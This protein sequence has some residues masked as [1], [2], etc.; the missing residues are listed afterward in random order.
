[1][2]KAQTQHL[3]DSR[4]NCRPQADQPPPHP[5]TQR[6]RI[7]Q[8]VW[9]LDAQGHRFPTSVRFLD[10]FC[11]L[12]PAMKAVVAMRRRPDGQGGK[13]LVA[14]ST[15]STPNGD[16][17]VNFV[18]RLFT[19]LAVADDRPLPAH[20]T[21]PWQQVQ[22]ERHHPGSILWSVSGSAIKRITAWREGL[23]LNVSAKLRS[24]DRPSPPGK[25]SLERKKNTA[26]SR[27]TLFSHSSL[28]PV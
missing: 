15:T 1:M 9:I 6:G 19:T 4:S 24:E 2:E 22:R 13:G 27:R 10:L 21:L 16:D 17:V 14:G 23:P 12:L 18:V 8:P 26:F 11:C 28:W 5:S 3:P 20:R 25:V 7:R